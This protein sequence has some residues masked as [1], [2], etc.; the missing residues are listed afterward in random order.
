MSRLTSKHFKGQRTNSDDR[1]PYSVTPC[2]EDPLLQPCLPFIDGIDGCFIPF[3]TIDSDLKK[4]RL[5]EGQALAC[6]IG[7]RP[8]DWPVLT[9]NG[10]QFPEDRYINRSFML[11]DKMVR[12]MELVASLVP[13][14]LPIIR[15]PEPQEPAYEA[16]AWNCIPQIWRNQCL[17]SRLQRL[18]SLRDIHR[19]RRIKL[20]IYHTSA[21]SF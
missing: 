13:N 12:R 15:A 18:R 11:S 4:Y 19:R 3:H 17:S 1:K 16:D 14:M 8:R 6:G 5:V 21:F 20:E 10:P 7:P 2:S 9:K